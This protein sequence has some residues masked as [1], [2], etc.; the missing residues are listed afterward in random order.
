[1][2]S[3]GVEGKGLILLPQ[4]RVP[5]EGCVEEAGA[6][7]SSQDTRQHSPVQEAGVHTGQPQPSTVALLSKRRCALS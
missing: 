6:L 4:Y 1:M 5:G 3:E 7:G 2:L